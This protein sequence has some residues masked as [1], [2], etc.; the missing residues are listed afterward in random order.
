MINL[1]KE[2]FFIILGKNPDDILMKE[3]RAENNSHQTQF[4][5]QVL[6]WNITFY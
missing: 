5:K 6:V 3:R 1:F 2:F 4:R